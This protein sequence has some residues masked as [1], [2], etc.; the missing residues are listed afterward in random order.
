MSRIQNILIL[1]AIKIESSSKNQKLYTDIFIH[2]VLAI[3]WL[4]VTARNCFPKT[5]RVMRKM[6][7]NAPTIHKS[8]CVIDSILPNRRLLISNWRVGIKLRVKIHPA[9]PHW[10][11]SSL[12]DSLV[13]SLVF[14]KKY[15]SKLAMIANIKL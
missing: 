11:I 10:D 6:I 4:R 5:E 12:L 8:V 14:S 9:I 1:R 3:L 15:M 7:A 13:I 2:L